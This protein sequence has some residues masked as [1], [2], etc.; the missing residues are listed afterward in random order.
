[1][2]TSNTRSGKRCGER[3]RPGGPQHGGGD[4]DDVVAFA[5]PSRDELVGEHVGP[6]RAALEPLERLAGLGSICPTAWN[7]S[8]SSSSAGCVAAA[9]LGDGVHDHRGAEVLR[10]ARGVSI[11]VGRSC[12]STGPRYLMS[13]FEYSAALLVNRLR[14][15]CS[16]AA[17]AAVERARRRA[18]ACRTAG[19]TRAVQV[20]V[21]VGGAHAVEEARHAADRR[22][23]G[24]AV[25]VDDDDEVAVVVVGDVV[26][27]LPRHAAGE[28]AV[29]DDGDDVPVV[30][31]R[32]ASKAREM[33]SAQHSELD[34]CEDSRRC[35]ARTLGALRVAGEAAARA[36]RR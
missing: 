27:R 12:P 5:R 25:V 21:G 14:K 7:W 6:R 30:A 2:P 33:P 10:R 11:S 15:P 3:C 1:M 9:L 26:E 22:R 8:A 13:R 16:A 23:V 31:G 20:A 28:R 18:R 34:A 24:A 29:A 35:R 17:H 19:R 36:Q 4:A 32:S